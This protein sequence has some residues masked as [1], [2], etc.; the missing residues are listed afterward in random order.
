[1]KPQIRGG[2]GGGNAED[3]V[4]EERKEKV[5]SDKCRAEGD[6]ADEIV[7]FFLSGILS[8]CFPVLEKGFAPGLEE[9]LQLISS[10]CSEA[11]L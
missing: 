4:R 11:Q 9:A 3:K 5:A 8:V 10:T 1:M 7:F 6:M 2:G